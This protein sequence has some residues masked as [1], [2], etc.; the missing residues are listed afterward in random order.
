MIIDDQQCRLCSRRRLLVRSHI[1]PEFAYEPIKNEK[2]QFYSIGLKAKTVQTG[3]FEKLL[4]V[5]CEGLLSV[6]ESD[7]KKC[8]MNTIPQDFHHLQTRPLHDAII[9]EVPDYDRFKLF[10][11]SVLWRAAV[12]SFKASKEISIEPYEDQLADLIKSGSPGQAGD[13]PFWAVLSLSPALR[14]V[15]TIS[16]LAQGEGTFEGHNYYMMSY[17]FCD[18][19]FILAQPGP[20]WLAEAEERSRRDGNFLLLTVPHRQSRSYELAA[21]TLRLH[22]S[23]NTS[24]HSQRHTRP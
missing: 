4:C 22:R 1:V 24:M 9:V 3:Y 2:G 10:H 13:F 7:F 5:D 6:Y 18:W 17:A 16:P 8:W 15:P 21:A 14:P 23:T 11:L 12:S 20:R 19:T